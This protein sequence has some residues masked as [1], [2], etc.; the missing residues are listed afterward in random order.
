[1][2]PLPPSPDVRGAEAPTPRI[3]SRRR[4]LKAAATAPVLMTLVSRPVLG[5][6]CVCPSGYLS[7]AASHTGKTPTSCSG[8]SPTAWASNTSWPTPYHATTKNGRNG[9]DATLYHCVVTG[10]NG[11]T[12]SGDTLRGVLQLS[13]DGGTRSL[14][15]YTAAALLNARKGLTPVLTETTVRQMWNDC[16][17]KGYYEPTAGVHWGAA[18]IITY[19]KSTLA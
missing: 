18:Q 14:G 8:L 2:D 6:Q 3:P 4:V 1:M 19:I 9:Y 5:G 17:S 11:Y 10:L 12:F 13:D 16:I 15:R 7:N